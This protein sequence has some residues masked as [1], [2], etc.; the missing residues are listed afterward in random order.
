MRKIRF[1]IAMIVLSSIF[2]IYI[3]S[4]KA[5][6]YMPFTVGVSD[7]PDNADPADA[8]WGVSCDILNQVYE[9]LYAC[10]LSSP[11]M[12]A[13]PQLASKM[14]VWNENL[15][16]LI[17]E[18]RD[19]VTFHDGSAFNAAAVKWNFDRI[20][21]F[22]ENEMSN[23]YFLYLNSDEDLIVKETM[24][25]N[26]SA[27]KFILNKP[28][29]IWEQ[30]LAFT[31]SYII[32][33]NDDFKN[34]F[35]SLSDEAIGTGPF[36]LGEITPDLSTIYGNQNHGSV[37]YKRYEDY[38]KGPANI[39]DMV[40]EVIEDSEVASTAM[41]NLELHY[42]GVLA[43]HLEQAET[44][45]DITIEQVKTPVVFY[46]S[47]SVK[48]IPYE[49]RRAMSFGFDYTYFLEYSPK[50]KN[51]EL[52]T[53]IPDG[54]Q[55]HNP[56]I[57]GLPYYNKTIARQYVLNCSNIT[58][59]Q[60][61]T[62]DSPDEDWIAVAE[63]DTPLFDA[64]FTRY[65]S[66]EVE[67]I[68]IQSVSNFKYLGIHVTDVYI[69]SYWSGWEQDKIDPKFLQISMGSWS[70]NFNDANTM[71]EPLY[72]TNSTYNEAG[73]ANDTLD[74]LFSQNYEK[75]GEERAD[76]FDNIVQ[77]LMVENCPSMYLY[78]RGGRITYNNK[79]VSN[80]TDLLNILGRS[81]WYN[82]MY[83]PQEASGILGFTLGYA[84]LVSA[85]VVALI[86]IQY[87]KRH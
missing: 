4:T 14:G 1:L 8:Y 61:L 42:G 35:L 66:T 49:V 16:E 17:I 68:L 60:E 46:L 65:Y 80:T 23:P 52:H 22:A 73:L 9:G 32:K 28:Y 63:S 85:G 57:E 87:R 84:L 81:Y 79:H 30:I 11:S 51:Y 34:T 67:K 44:D 7:T 29:S 71:I 6:R 5:V 20:N 75:V 69:D 82:V 77:K 78:Q 13:I 76:S 3:P 39:T 47:L 10:N 56:D 26:N 86:L 38:Y 31:G 58:D 12:E 15:T 19:D 54:M 25:V 45:P 64:N 33:P 70:T 18:L 83:T 37:L 74:V 50:N 40:Y 72:K 2:S 24:I 62:I 43:E 55:Y 36:K 41:L 21:F 59:F 53:P 27:I 48:N